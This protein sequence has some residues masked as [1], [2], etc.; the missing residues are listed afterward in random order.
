MGDGES[1]SCDA[2]VCKVPFG[3]SGAK[4][5]QRREPVPRAGAE[6][7]GEPFTSDSRCPP[8][9]PPTCGRFTTQALE[10]T[11][12]GSIYNHSQ[13]KRLT[14]KQTKSE[15]RKDQRKCSRETQQGQQG[16]ERAPEQGPSPEG[17]AGDGTGPRTPTDFQGIVLLASGWCFSFRPPPDALTSAAPRTLPSL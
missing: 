8:D 13:R 5:L 3:W 9:L 10:L 16:K 4:P 17:G 11:V 14:G 1:V 12:T 7:R 6:R 2:S 15:A